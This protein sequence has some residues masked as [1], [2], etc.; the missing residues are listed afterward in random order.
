MHNLLNTKGIILKPAKQLLSK[1]DVT[2]TNNRGQIP[3]ALRSSL[4]GHIHSGV[5]YPQSL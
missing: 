2:H 3:S 5:D 4:E 1:I